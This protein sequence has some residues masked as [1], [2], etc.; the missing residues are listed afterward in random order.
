MG[1]VLNIGKDHLGSD[2]IETQEDLCMTKS[3]VVEVVK[4]TGFSILNADDKTTMTI[5]NRARGN[6]ILFS[7][8]PNNQR[9]KAH[10][11]NGGIAVTLVGRN[12]IIRGVNWI[13]TLHAGRNTHYFRWNNRF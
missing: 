8:N 5:L 9:I 4:K 11:K 10:V 1:V 7:L 13:S 12:V 3:T 6:V 2:W